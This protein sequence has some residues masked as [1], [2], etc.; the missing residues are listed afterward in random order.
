LSLGWQEASSGTDPKRSVFILNY[1]ERIPHSLLGGCLFRRKVD[2]EDAKS[3]KTVL[4]IELS[5]GQEHSVE[6]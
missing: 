6:V 3:F 4:I 1:R 2:R 5:G